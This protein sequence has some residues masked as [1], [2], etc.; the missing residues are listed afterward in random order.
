MV[1]WTCSVTAIWTRPSELNI[2]ITKKE[3][4]TNDMTQSLAS[5]SVGTQVLLA[6]HCVYWE[7]SRQAVWVHSKCWRKGQ[8][9][10][11]ALQDMNI[12]P[13]RKWHG[14][15]YKKIIRHI[16]HCTHTTCSHSSKLQSTDT[17]SCLPITANICPFYHHFIVPS[18][19]SLPIACCVYLRA[20][21]LCILMA[22]GMNDCRYNV[23][24]LRGIINLSLVCTY[25]QNQIWVVVSHQPKLSSVCL[26][27]VED[28]L[29]ICFLAFSH[30]PH[31]QYNKGFGKNQGKILMSSS[32]LL[33]LRHAM[34]T[35]PNK[36][37]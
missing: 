33:D 6:L 37:C 2:K 35:L 23:V 12:N 3:K 5:D 13:L 9:A 32:H 11:F 1:I 14:L 20:C 4:N 26:S 17:N 7:K 25:C 29:C 27:L 31:A 21:W 30:F 28:K 8:K 24:F 22:I 16:R 36:P 34:Q 18:S 10:H 19:P 15:H